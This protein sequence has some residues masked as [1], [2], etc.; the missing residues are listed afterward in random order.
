MRGQP[1]DL[2]AE[3]AE[4]G[5]RDPEGGRQPLRRSLRQRGHQLPALLEPLLCAST[6]LGFDSEVAS[7]AAAG[8]MLHR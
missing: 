4:A 5:G 2:T 3:G 1:A 8:G 6:T 7:A